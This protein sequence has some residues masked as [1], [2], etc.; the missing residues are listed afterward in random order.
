MTLDIEFKHD[1]FQIKQKWNK[2]I[3]CKLNNS[4]KLNYFVIYSQSQKVAPPLSS[5]VLSIHFLKPTT[6]LYT[7]GLPFKRKNI[8]RIA[9]AVTITLYSKVTMLLSILL[10]SIVRNVI[11]VSSVMS[12]VTKLSKT[13]KTPQKSENI[14]KLSKLSKI[15]YNV[16]TVKK[17]SKL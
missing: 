12:Q 11:S 4:W 6:L 14:Q 17:L 9:N 15:V 16:N 1:V 5:I 13:L 3:L 2:M 8:A 7:P 10:F